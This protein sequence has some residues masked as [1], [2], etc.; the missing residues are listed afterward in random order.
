[1]LFGRK[2]LPLLCGPTPLL[3][4]PTLSK[5]LGIALYFKRDDMTPLA[6][7]GNKLRKLEYLAAEAVEQGA[8]TLLTMGGAQT[9][10]GRLTAAVAAK[11]GLK[12]HILC[13]D[14]YPGELS[15][16]LL[17]DRIMGAE[18]TL[19]EDD[20]RPSD[21][22]LAELE[23]EVTARL[24]SAG[25]RVYSIPIGGSNALGMLGYYEC[26][27][28]LTEQ[29]ARMNLGE[30]RVVVAAGSL[31][32]YLG[33]FCG[34]RE[35]GSTLGL[36]GVAISPFDAEKMARLLAYHAEVKALYGLEAEVSAGDF[37]MEAGYV[38]GGYNVPS[39]EVREAVEQVA[40]S[41]GV[42]LDPCYTGKAFAG[43]MDMVREGKIAQGETVI[44][45]HTGGMPG[46]YTAHHRREMEQELLCGVAIE[47]VKG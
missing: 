47:T 3:H 1:M 38:R 10:H 6:L 43:L 20:G 18:V 28:E 11:L 12:C 27:L 46:L 24:E 16:N 30:A 39:R 45:L 33:L 40:R 32:T 21:V 42:L 29:A 7:G 25:E 37:H 2:K 5:E 19:R 13:I 23:A 35:S 26:A 36:T 8:T 22:Q 41:E 44:F 34:L 14:S 31:G 4:M 9:N 15:A 17:L